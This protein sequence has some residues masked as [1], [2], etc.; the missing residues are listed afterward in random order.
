MFKPVVY[1]TEGKSN[2]LNET[3]TEQQKKAG[4]NREGE[5]LFRHAC[6]Q[7]PE[8]E[9]KKVALSFSL[10]SVLS[11]QSVVRVDHV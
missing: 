4:P 1:V 5:N 9:V 6:A 10:V 7:K 11:C 2:L 3:A 8:A